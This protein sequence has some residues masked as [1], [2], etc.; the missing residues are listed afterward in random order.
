MA[1][2]KFSGTAATFPNFLKILSS[3]ESLEATLARFDEQ[4]ARHSPDVIRQR[5]KKRLC[6]IKVNLNGS[7]ECS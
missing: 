2:D 1:V 3:R 7:D 4:I 6:K 5:L